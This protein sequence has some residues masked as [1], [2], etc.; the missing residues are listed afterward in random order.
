MNSNGNTTITTP[1]GTPVTDVEVYGY[2]W[3]QASFGNTY[4]TV[5]VFVNGNE[6]YRSPHMVYGYGDHYQQT[7]LEQ[8]A[9][10]VGIEQPRNAAWKFFENHGI[11]YASKAFDVKRKRDMLEFAPFYG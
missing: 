5:I 4:H 6:I 9:E 1:D 10:W 7:A 8:F 11:T 2:R 3:F